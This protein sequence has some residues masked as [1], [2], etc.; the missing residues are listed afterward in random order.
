MAKK[1]KRVEKWRAAAAEGGSGTTARR[2]GAESG[3]RG[4]GGR[5]PSGISRRPAP[6]RSRF[7]LGWLLGAVAILIVAVAAIVYAV[8]QNDDDSGELAAADQTATVVAALPSAASAPAA[9]DPFAQPIPTTAGVALANDGDVASGC[10]TEDQRTTDGRQPLQ[11]S[12][13]P[14]TVIDPTQIYT[15]QL[16]TNYGPMTWQLLPGASLDAVNSFVCLSRA[17]YY[18]GAPFHRI[19]DDFVIQGGDPTG[20]GTGGPGYSVAD[21]PVVGG[22]G[23]GVVS[24][25]RTAQP[26]STGSQFFINIADNTASFGPDPTYINFAR[27]IAGQQTVDAI[28]SVERVLGGD[29]A[30]SSPVNPVILETVTIYQGGLPTD[31][32]AA[33][34]A[35]PGAGTPTSDEPGAG[36]PEAETPV[37]AITTIGSPEVG[38]PI[39]A[40]PVV[41]APGGATPVALEATPVTEVLPGTPIAT[42]AA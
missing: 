8:N 42:P 1:T 34:A 9:A 39:A 31:L 16:Q 18:N 6:R 3:G 35:T 38:T 32:G 33:T 23:V 2:A 41:T 21:S 28:A 5:G 19:V 15:A 40:T 36:T 7:P 26:N 37:A 30:I 22:Y 24:M 27:V 14:A 10:W 25:A 17:G 4:P 20:T 12:A 11:W 29:N 13:A